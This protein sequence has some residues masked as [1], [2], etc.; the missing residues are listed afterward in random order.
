VQCG[1]LTVRAGDVVIADENGVLVLP[2]HEAVEIGNASIARQQ[3]VNN[4]ASKVKLGE[5]LGD[6]SGATKLVEA[7]AQFTSE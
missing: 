4:T 3:R 5:K 7:E 1:G 6:L 2:R